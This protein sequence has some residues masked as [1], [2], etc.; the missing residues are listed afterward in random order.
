MLPQQN[1]EVWL[2][3]AEL[4][5]SWLLRLECALISCV[6]SGVEM[7]FD[8]CNSMQSNTCISKER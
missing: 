3:H 7:S 8:C 5:S 4:I 1:Q 2:A 6:G